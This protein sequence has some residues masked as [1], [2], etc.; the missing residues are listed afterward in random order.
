MCGLVFELKMEMGS[1][2]REELRASNQP[3]GVPKQKV[4]E[5]IWQ[6]NG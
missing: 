2:Q 1:S 6:M 3:G 4:N 5:C